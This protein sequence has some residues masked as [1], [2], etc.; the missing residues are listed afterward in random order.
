MAARPNLL[1]IAIDSLRRDHMSL[2]GYH[3]LTTP[4]L[5]RFAEQGTMFR[6][7]FS[8]SVPT[9]PAYASMLTGRD[10]FGTGVV[11]LRHKGD[12]A[13]P[14]L[15]E[16]LERAGYSTC[17]VGFPGNPASRGFRTYLEY[18]GWGDA[19]GGAMPKAHALNEVAVPYLRTAAAGGDPFFLFLRHMD[20]HSP[21]LPP[22]PFDRLFYE[23][24]ELDPANRSLDRLYAFAPF[25]DYFRSW[26][27][28][29]VTD[30][31]FVD[32]LYDGA[33]A[34]MDAAIGRLFTVLDELGLTENTVVVVTADHGETLN[35]HE[36]WY[37]HHGLYDSNL[38]VPLIIRAPGKLP[39]GARVDPWVQTRDM[40]PTMLDLLGV[41]AGLEF[42]GRSLLPPARGEPFVPETE[43]YL[44]EATWMRKHGWRTPEWKLIRALEPDFHR[45]PEVELYNL[46]RDPDET[47]NL[48]DREPAVVALLEERM[49]A[50][51]ERREAQTGRRNPMFTQLGWHGTGDAPFA[52]SEEAYRKLH[53]GSRKQ[54]QRLQAHL[55]KE[56]P[57]EEHPAE[58]E[59][60]KEGDS[61]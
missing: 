48:A 6:R 39:A 16:I 5:A 41:D 58:A 29:K 18:E 12:V 2:Y 11:G 44:T 55:S 47:E 4:H 25:A 17:C 28:G 60:H 14:M 49:A 35:E 43:L 53:I 8:P 31:R 24:D 50:H 27:P 30:A 19:P 56:H 42:D 1:L 32:S 33:V 22:A 20:P 36:C 9:T 34:Y 57:A 38:V 40:T 13:A 52:S 45:K 3:R 59:E 54:A 51:V 7:P 23:G 15:P 61:P 26:F 37:D 46:V 21:Y 10:C